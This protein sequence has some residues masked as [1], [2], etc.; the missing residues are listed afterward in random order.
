MRRTACLTAAALV[1]LV[2]VGCKE[3]A[4]QVE[5]KPPGPNQIA[6][7]LAKTIEQ[8][9]DVDD[10]R[11]CATCHSAVYEEWT[12]SMHSKAHK[13]QDPIYAAMRRLRISKGQKIEGKC[14]NCHAPRAKGEYDSLAAR[15]GVS[16]ATCHN[17]E[18]VHP[19]ELAKGAKQLVFAPDDTM[20]SA[21]DVAPGSSPVHANGPAHPAL[22]DGKTLCLACHGKHTNPAKVPVCTTGSELEA[23]AGDDTCVSCHMPPAD[24]PS[25]AVSDRKTHRSHR[26]PGPHRAYL[27]GD[28]SLLASGVEM[29][30]ELRGE[31]LK[32]TLRNKSGHSF[33][34]GF[35][36][37]FAVLGLT[38]L[39]D[40]G[41]VV[42]RNFDA[43]PMK[44]SPQSVLNK[45][46][47]T[48]DGQPT[49]PPLAT[50]LGRDSRLEPDEVRIIEFPVPG[51]VKTVQA[52]LRYGLLPA[53]AA[54]ALELGDDPL[55]EPVEILSVR[56]TRG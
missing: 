18:A 6:R 28:P 5:T 54:Q 33:P 12:E 27:Q 1:A 19:S 40:G 30:V 24:G 22:A 9:I 26:F 42:W 20:R 37:R 23:H 36:G 34:S 35:P 50:K 29:Q 47:T 17:L 31:T 16:C 39:D 7:E 25:G 49:L 2:G 4:A 53:S 32:V 41:E 43:D 3:R 38:G 21:R 11:T 8:P 55:T 14:E 10:P 15:T 45:V 46:Y 13:T 52:K 56:A 44:R 51:T 48:E